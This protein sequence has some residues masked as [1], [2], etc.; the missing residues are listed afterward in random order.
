MHGD[1]DIERIFIMSSWQFSI[2]LLYLNLS[3]WKI[4]ASYIK[5]SNCKSKYI[6]MKYAGTVYKPDGIQFSGN[7]ING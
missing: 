3:N 5:L 6:D 2:V 7:F 4:N 1:G